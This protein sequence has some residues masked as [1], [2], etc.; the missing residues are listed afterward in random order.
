MGASLSDYTIDLKC[1]DRLI[2]T[3]HN[4]Y[5]HMTMGVSLREASLHPQQM[6]IPYSAI[7]RWGKILVNL[8]NWQPFANVLPTNIFL[9]RNIFYRHLLW[10]PCVLYY[11]K[12]KITMLYV[13]SCS[14]YHLTTLMCCTSSLG[15]TRD[16]VIVMTYDIKFH[17]MT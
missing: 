14:L 7:M 16:D 5:V 10:Q 13:S 11:M 6:C 3:V 17:D 9:T 12:W 2:S 15:C 1:L 8:V 4:T